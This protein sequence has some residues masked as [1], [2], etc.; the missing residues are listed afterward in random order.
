LSQLSKSEWFP[1]R[2]VLSLGAGYFWDSEGEGIFPEISAGYRFF[3]ESDFI[4]CP[5][6]KLRHTFMI[7]KN[8]PYITDFSL[9][10]I[11]GVKTF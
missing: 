7:T 11:L 5:Y 10:M 1:S 4:F 6:I 8:K 9:G 3:D 2:E